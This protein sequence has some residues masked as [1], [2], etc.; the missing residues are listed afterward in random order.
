MGCS[1]EKSPYYAPVE[2]WIEPAHMTLFRSGELADRAREA[3]AHLAS[4]DLC[5]RYCRVD[6]F[7]G[8]KGPSAEP[9]SAPWST[10]SARTMAKSDA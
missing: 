9:A 7:Q 3:T 2:P 10:A 1:P 6:R 5:A 4:C 8:V